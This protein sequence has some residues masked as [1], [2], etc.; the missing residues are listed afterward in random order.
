M[1]QR[2]SGSVQPHKHCPVC[3][4]SIAPT[5]DYCSAECKRVDEDAQV[6][7]KRYRRLTLSL[8][9]AAMV[10]LVVLTIY[11]RAH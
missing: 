6:R 3:G 11:L 7:V 1:S 2:A 5:K 9:V 10:A 4:I 8:M